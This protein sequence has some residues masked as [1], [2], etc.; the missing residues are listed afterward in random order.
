MNGIRAAIARNVA[1]AFDQVAPAR[2]PWNKAA[3]S[4]PPAGTGARPVVLQGGIATDASMYEPMR[5]FLAT[6]GFD[7]TIAR[8]PKQT[9]GSIRGDAQALQQAVDAASLR[10]IQ[11][12]GDGLVDIFAH[13]KG[14]LIARDYIQNLDGIDHVGQLIT[15]GTPHRGFTLLHPKVSNIAGRVLPN[16]AFRDLE[17]ANGVAAQLNRDLPAFMDEAATRQPGFR[18]VS[19]A[20]D[21]GI[22]NDGLI[23]VPSTKLPSARNV[24]HHVI[25]ARHANHGSIAGCILGLHGE[26]A[27]TAANLLGGHSLDA[28]A[29]NARTGAS[30]LRAVPSPT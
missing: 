28:S 16:A 6:A 24:E 19:L 10:S 4:L 7:V 5:R 21:V 30:L 3:A 26:S 12:G 2:M 22:G 14:G 23:T 1:G 8:S 9:L 29:A 25:H 18:M 15:S 13:S 11:G 20:G 27:R 17:A